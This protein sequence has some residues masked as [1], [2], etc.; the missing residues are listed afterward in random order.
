M[1][2]IPEPESMDTMEEA[3]ELDK[4]CQKYIY[5][6][7]EAMARSV[8]RMG[9]K[10]GNVL[11]IGIGPARIA[12][13]IVNYNPGL[14]VFGI[15]LSE[16]MLTIAKNNIKQFNIGK[17]KIN[18]IRADG[19]RLPFK[20]NTFDLVLSHNML[21][22]I[23]DPVPLLKEVKRVVRPEGGIL[24]R[25]LIRPPNKFIAKLYSYIFGVGYT[26]KM[27]RLYYESMLAAFSKDEIKKMLKDAGLDVVI[28]SHFLTHY[29][30]ERLPRKREASK[31]KFNR[32]DP[33]R[34]LSLSFYVSG[35]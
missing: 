5:I 12:S 32:L 23:P 10:I 9:I 14:T 3:V 8:T 34:E 1:E 28:R 35:G 31:T 27:R 30:L 4:M 24:I 21:H 25:D 7:D 16:S 17:G 26:E 15:D 29:S 22:H 33:F 13:K 19:K 2:R 11:E 18:L 20:D 6:L